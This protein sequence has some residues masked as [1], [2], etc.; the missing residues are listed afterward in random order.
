MNS[1]YYLHTNGE[2]IHK[3]DPFNTIEQDLLE[4]SFVVNYWKVDNTDRS[5]AWKILIEALALGAKKERINELAIK[6][7]CTNE[8]AINYA[9]RKDITLYKD[10]LYYATTNNRSY[11][12]IIG[13]G[14]SY[15]E[16]FSDLYKQI[17]GFL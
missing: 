11:N 8:D 3:N 4:S 1:Y 12:K 10:D 9:L 6:W 16:A 13:N 7:N 17:Y 14:N 2:L 15:L 5:N